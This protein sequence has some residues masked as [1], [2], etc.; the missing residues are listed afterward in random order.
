MEALTP[1]KEYRRKCEAEGKDVTQFNAWCDT[2]V[3]AEKEMN[4]DKPLGQIFVFSVAERLM[5]HRKD[6]LEEEDG[7]SGAWTSAEVAAYKILSQL[8]AKDHELARLDADRKFVT[9]KLIKSKDITVQDEKQKPIVVGSEHQFKTKGAV[10]WYRLRDDEYGVNQI[11]V[12]LKKREAN[13]GDDDELFPEQPKK[14]KKKKK[15]T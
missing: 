9:G 6:R 12:A 11:W 10:G 7:V 13:R 14:K 2:I 5:K 15:T 8:T 1:T 3:A 4:P